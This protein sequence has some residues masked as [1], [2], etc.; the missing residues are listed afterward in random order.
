MPFSRI[1]PKLLNVEVTECPR[2]S[3][4]VRAIEPSVG[5]V[6]VTVSSWR[7]TTLIPK[8]PEIVVSKVTLSLPL[9]RK[10]EFKLLL[11]GLVKSILA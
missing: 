2:L 4:M 6:N 7:S 5:L 10:D 8:V 11:P 3:V 9:R 1:M